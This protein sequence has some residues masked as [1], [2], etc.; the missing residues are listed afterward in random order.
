MRTVLS[1]EQRVL[2]LFPSTQKKPNQTPTDVPSESIVSYT[3]QSIKNTIPRRNE[4]TSVEES[5]LPDSTLTA[6]AW[7]DREGKEE[8][9]WEETGEHAERSGDALRK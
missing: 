2:D 1:S 3:V 8:M 4:R 7:G 9:T 6:S 5:M